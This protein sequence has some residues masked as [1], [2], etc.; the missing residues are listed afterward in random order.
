M[1]NIQQWKSIKNNVIDI[2][3]GYTPFILYDNRITFF[4]TVSICTCGAMEFQC[5]ATAQVQILGENT[6]S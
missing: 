6:L 1:H 5:I 4:Y 2:T 3:Q